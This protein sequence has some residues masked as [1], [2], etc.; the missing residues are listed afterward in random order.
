ML[1]C[2]TIIYNANSLFNVL[3]A[4]K[5]AVKILQGSVY[6][7]SKTFIMIS[8][9][10]SWALSK[11]QYEEGDDAEEDAEEGEDKPKI[12]VKPY[13]P[14]TVEGTTRRKA[15]ENFTEL[16]EVEKRVRIS[17][18]KLLRTFIF[19]SG[20]LYGDGERILHGWFKN[21]WEGKESLEVLDH[22]YNFVPMIH[23]KDLA[24]MVERLI[25]VPPELDEEDKTNSYIIAVD[26]AHST[27]NQIIG[28]I[29]KEF[30][31]PQLIHLSEPE[32]RSLEFRDELSIDLK[33]TPKEL[34]SF[35]EM[36]WHC[37]DGFVKKIKMIRREF[38]KVRRLDPLRIT[39]L[40]PPGVGKTYY[41]K[42][43]SSYYK[44]P[45]ISIKDTIEEFFSQIKELE[46]NVEKLTP[47]KIE[48]KKPERQDEEEAEEVAEEE[49]PEE[50]PEEDENSPLA[51]AKKKL[52]DLL[53]LKSKV[54]EQGRFKDEVLAKIFKWKLGQRTSRNQGWIL[55]NYPKTAKQCQLLMSKLQPEEGEEPEEE[56]EPVEEEEEAEGKADPL[57]MPEYI[58]HFDMKKTL[59]EKR[60]MDLPQDQ[61]AGTHN[62][63]DDFL[64]R[65]KFYEENNQPDETGVLTQL[66]ELQRVDEVQPLVKELKIQSLDQDVPSTLETIYEF[67]GLPH[68][69]GVT[70]TEIE[71]EEKKKYEAEQERIRQEEE[72]KKELEEKLRKEKSDRV[73]YLQEEEERLEAIKRQEKEMLNI[74][75]IPLRQYLTDNVLP[76]LTEGLIEVCRMKPADPVDYLAEYLF[77]H[78]VNNLAGEK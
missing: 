11:K 23:V 43:L 77:K 19:F 64:R 27:Q 70:K 16:I 37:K 63:R 78:N 13:E 60:L 10:M 5:L 9:V 7:D 51:K 32:C 58:I 71:R 48:K 76:V 67:I 46:R 59:I 40:G 61:V 65:Y 36:E 42:L 28:S 38:E 30:G 31:A 17:Q 54:D 21:A 56:E 49:E 33:F 24:S 44:I 52:N 75:S 20:L 50:E 55:D 8:S 25:T 12:K 74:R 53:K 15:H 26:E 18:S 41:G 6:T 62:N 66:E 35:E 68:N 4:I 47:P 57:C 22:G 29:A 3:P 72:E 14:L 69:Y 1:E 73:Q 34:S 2:D 39:L 45:L